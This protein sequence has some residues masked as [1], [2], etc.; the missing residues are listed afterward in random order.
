MKFRR[1]NLKWILL[2]ASILVAPLIW[3]EIRH[4]KSVQRIYRIGFDNQPPQH[5]PGRDGKP[6]GLSFG[7]LLEYFC[8]DRSHNVAFRDTTLVNK[9]GVRRKFR[10]QVGAREGALAFWGH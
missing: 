8:K 7:S 9:T 1:Q 5:F 4:F 10:L 3:F 2:L 6:D